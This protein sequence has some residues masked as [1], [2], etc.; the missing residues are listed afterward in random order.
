MLRPL[1][2][3]RAGEIS[4]AEFVRRT[5]KDWSRLTAHLYRRYRLP[6]GVEVDD[7][8]QEMLVRA[9]EAVREWDPAS[10]MPLDRFV[11]WKAY[12]KANRWIQG[13]RNAARRGSSAPSR[14]PAEFSSF[15]DTAKEV[16]VDLVRTPAA[17]IEDRVLLGELLDALSSEGERVAFEFWIAAGG[18]S[19][20]AVTDLLADEKVR[21]AFRLTTRESAR[22]FL[23][24]ALGA[25]S[26]RL[27]A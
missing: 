10:T 3:L 2:A 9:W 6:A 25:A 24:S 27:A 11:T 18:D 23:K 8:A 7:V 14:F 4:F 13:Q 19:T 20:E 21:L 22:R 1:S 16:I 17:T 15:G 26:S 5:S 12:A